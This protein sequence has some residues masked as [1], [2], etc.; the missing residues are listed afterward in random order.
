RP[1]RL[2][3]TE[4]IRRLVRETDLRPAQL[5]YPMFVRTGRGLRE[6]IPSMPGNYHLSPELLVDEV[7]PLAEAGL[8]AVILFGVP[9][10]DEKDARAAAAYDDDGVVQ[11]AVARLKDALPDLVVITD[12]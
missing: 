10:E 8:A 6:E 1:R 4:T 7:R 5:V 2:R 11:Q 9:G 12:V 3:R